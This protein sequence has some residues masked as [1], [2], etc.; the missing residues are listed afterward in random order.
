MLQKK[1]EKLHYTRCYNI[2]KKGENMSKFRRRIHR[3]AEFSKCL[4]IIEDNLLYSTENIL[5]IL[6]RRGYS[7]KIL[8]NM[9]EN[10]YISDK[11]YKATI[12]AYIKRRKNKE[13]LLKRSRFLY[14]EDKY[15]TFYILKKTMLLDIVDN[16]KFCYL[17]MKGDE[18]YISKI[19]LKKLLKATFKKD[20]FIYPKIKDGDAYESKAIIDFNENFLGK[21]LVDYYMYKCLKFD[22]F[23]T[24]NIITINNITY[25]L[26]D[27]R[28]I[29]S[30]I[31]KILNSGEYMKFNDRFCNYST[32]L[33]NTKE[34]LR[35]IMDINNKN[36][37]YEYNETLNRYKDDMKITCEED[38]DS[39]YEKSIEEIKNTITDDEC[40][41]F[42]AILKIENEKESS[43]EN[44][45]T[46]IDDL[47]H[48]FDN[49]IRQVFY[50]H[51]KAILLVLLIKGYIYIK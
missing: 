47:S 41:V 35:V 18:V 17:S 28:W 9:M 5:G 1:G 30:N 50:T 6:R 19:N 3:I 48:G 37:N 21:K 45:I 8:N 39:H 27:R 38:I 10:F 43:Y 42:E 31:E 51:N 36:T 25:H 49:I 23:Y 32:V 16:Y 13:N 33:C 11:G 20:I 15:N 12:R 46:T 26:N 34:F 7:E 29:H 44:L 2:D 24:K 40:R 4:D 14:K 22:H